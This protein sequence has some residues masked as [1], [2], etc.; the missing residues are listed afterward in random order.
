LRLIGAWHLTGASTPCELCLDLDDP[1]REQYE[2]IKTPFENWNVVFESR[3]GLARVYNHAFERHPN[4]PWYGF[5]AD[6]VVPITHGWDTKL[7]EVAG[8]DGMA[9]PAGG[10]T[11][12]GCPHFVIGEDLVRSMGWLS[13]PGLDRIYIDTVWGDVSKSRG[14]YREVAGVKLEHHHF[15]NGKALIDETY[16]KHQKRQDKLIYDNWRKQH[17]YLP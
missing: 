3:G 8:N 13:L 10:E 12:G 16:R 17:A 11:T 6:D 5:I 1:F 2:E 14:V 4:E 9:V 7:I 15:S